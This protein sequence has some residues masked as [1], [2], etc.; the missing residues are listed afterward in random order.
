MPLTDREREVATFVA[1]RFYD[2]KEFTT[3]Q[4]LLSESKDPTLINRLSNGQVWTVNTTVYPP[5]YCPTL[6]TF[7]HCSN[8]ELLRLA[9]QSVELVVKQIKNIFEK[10]YDGRK[11]HVVWDFLVQLRDSGQSRDAEQITLG[12]FLTKDIPST[13][14]AALNDA[15]TGVLS[16]QINDHILN[17]DPV[18]VWDNYIQAHDRIAQEDRITAAQE[19]RPGPPEIPKQ[20]PKSPKAPK[21]KN[22]LPDRWKIVEPL[23]EGGQGWTYKVRRS[24]GSDQALYVLKRLKNKSRVER[25]RKEIVALQKIQHR[26]ILRIIEASAESEEPFFVSELCEG[27]DLDSKN[28][29][30][31]TLEIKLEIFRQICDAVAAAHKANILH[32]D[33]KPS[34]IFIRSD[35]SVAVGDFGLCIDLT[36]L[37]DRATKTSEAIG[38]RMYIAPELESG[39]V[40]EPEASSDVYS[41]GKV[42]YFILSGRDLLR[43]EYTEPEDDLRK[44]NPEPEMH[45]VYE[46]FDKSLKRNPNQRIQNASGLLD[47]LDG[48]ILRVRAKAH[49]LDMSAP[50]RCVYCGMGQYYGRETVGY[51]LMLVCNKCG[52]IQH[53]T[54]GSGK[55]WW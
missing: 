11:N 3:H 47:I 30:R 26:N 36:E 2:R 13:I 55:G 5:T 8:S 33:L 16:F 7:H 38:A 32:R 45:F 48:V 12:L 15:K 14:S 6:L 43:E 46:M 27:L 41:L 4:Q 50:Q 40:D 31:S 20:R 22:W 44:L 9:K 23:G 35:G 21:A 54:S 25:F 51:E 19:N 24:G 39:R 1:K 18:K 10:D 29:S 37:A 28:P 49:V 52:N 42:L 53:F 34:N 17:Q